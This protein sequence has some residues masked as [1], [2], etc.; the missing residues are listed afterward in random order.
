MIGEGSSRQ[1]V[2]SPFHGYRKWSVQGTVDKLTSANGT[3]WPVGGPLTAECLPRMFVPKV[4]PCPRAP[5]LR[6]TPGCGIYA[7]KNLADGVRQYTPT[8]HLWGEVDLWGQVV[9]HELGYRAQFA[10]PTCLYEHGATSATARRLADIYGVPLLPFPEAAIPAPDPDDD[11][12][13]LCGF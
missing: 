7:W 5:S 4:N 11:W 10:E 1:F 12:T 13:W 3:E 2:A 6:H 8:W 9:P